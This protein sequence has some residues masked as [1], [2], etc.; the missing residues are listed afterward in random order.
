[1]I[2]ATQAH[3][4]SDTNKNNIEDAF[5]TNKM[6][7]IEQEIQGACKRGKFFVTVTLK[8]TNQS[9]SDK[10]KA[11]LEKLGFTVNID[12]NQANDVAEISW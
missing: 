12:R 5:I 3:A 1:M 2:N 10:I 11:E 4:K 8:T 6:A 9:I 7:N